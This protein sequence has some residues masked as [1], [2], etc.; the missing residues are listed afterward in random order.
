MTC[1]VCKKGSTQPGKVTVTIDK[2]VTVVVVREVPAQVCSTCGEE[3]IDAETMREIEKLV[4]SAQI[5]GLHIAV[6]TFKAAAA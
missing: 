3:Y 4:T 2:G 5:A 1:I 6:Q